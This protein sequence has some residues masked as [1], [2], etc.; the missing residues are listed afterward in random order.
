MNTRDWRDVAVLTLVSAAMASAT[1]YLFKHPSDAAF[2]IWGTIF[3]TTV[4]AYHWLV[5]HDD[6]VPDHES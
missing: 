5:M 6:K 2:G 4:T 3:T 1:V